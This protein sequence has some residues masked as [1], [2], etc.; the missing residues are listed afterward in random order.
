M[1]SALGRVANGSMGRSGL[2]AGY[3][4]LIIS[5]IY[6][7]ENHASYLVYSMIFFTLG[8]LHFF[9]DGFIWKLRNPQ[10]A[11]SVGAVS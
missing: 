11:R 7:L 4:A 3:I 6:L 9:Y 5:T 10:V 1:D 2:L 8:A